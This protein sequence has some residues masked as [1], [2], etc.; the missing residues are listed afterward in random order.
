MPALT[1]ELNRRKSERVPLTEPV[2]LTLEEKGRKQHEVAET[3]NV[4]S[5]G[6]LVRVRRPYP[7][8][9]RLR[10]DV[11]QTG[12]HTLARVVRVEAPRPGI[13]HLGL[14]LLQLPSNFWGVRTPPRSWTRAA[15]TVWQG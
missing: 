15:E 5:D 10:V 1:F 13:W 4:S 7:V 9:S 2:W 3:V 14:Q 8:G 6:A 12:Q 11:P